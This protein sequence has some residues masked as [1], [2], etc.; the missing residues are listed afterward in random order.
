MTGV[1]RIVSTKEYATQMPNVLIVIDK[2]A[3]DN[4]QAITGMIRAAGRAGA[5]IKAEVAAYR[6]AVENG[7]APRTRCRHRFIDGGATWHGY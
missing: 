3:R 4:A 2:Y 7:Q 1:V 6:K 5:A